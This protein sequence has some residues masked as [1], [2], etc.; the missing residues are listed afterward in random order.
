MANLKSSDP[1]V[2]TEAD[3]EVDAETA[4]AISRGL[5]EVREGRMVPAE[6]VRKLIPEWI[7][8]FS[9]PNQR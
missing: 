4:D 8:K 1:F 2:S 3:V 6:E 5:R 7:S 9:T